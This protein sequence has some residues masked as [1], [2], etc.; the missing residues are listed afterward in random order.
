[1]DF[2]K[3]MLFSYV[4]SVLMKFFFSANIKSEQ[5]IHDVFN[6][7]LNMKLIQLRFSSLLNNYF[8]VKIKYWN[9]YE[10][11]R[12]RLRFHLDQLRIISWRMNISGNQ[13]RIENER[14]CLG[15]L[16]EVEQTIANW[17]STLVQQKNSIVSLTFIES[18]QS[19]FFKTASF[20]DI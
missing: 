16:T 11:Y 14:R 2:T 7:Y 5:S 9:Y 10:E 13:T 1:M 6:T 12:E 19:D 20:D 15:I 3:S 18:N 17:E 8:C 4:F